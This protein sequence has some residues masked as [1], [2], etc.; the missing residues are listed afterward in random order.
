[1]SNQLTGFQPISKLQAVDA[2]EVLKQSNYML[3][4]VGEGYFQSSVKAYEYIFGD[5]FTEL[6]L[7]VAACDG[8][9]CLSFSLMHNGHQWAAVDEM[10]SIQFTGDSIYDL[11]ASLKSQASECDTG[12][13]KCIE[14]YIPKSPLQV[15][16]TSLLSHR[17]LGFDDQSEEI[18][19]DV[20]PALLKGK[21]AEVKF[22][23]TMAFNLY[24]SNENLGFKLS[25]ATDKTVLEILGE[26]E[27]SPSNDAD[28]SYSRERIEV[29]G[30]TQKSIVVRF[31]GEVIGSSPNEDV[32]WSIQASHSQA[33]AAI[34]EKQ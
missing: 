24:N 25:K 14:D 20:N 28:Y 30:L 11:V 7:V 19:I 8:E 18:V 29:D 1:M 26:V 9:E 2:V 32:A 13:V 33:I 10:E 27:T 34:K 6:D 15:T 31:K 21:E 5:N 17:K 3:A 4:P 23:E 16:I 12:I 22:I